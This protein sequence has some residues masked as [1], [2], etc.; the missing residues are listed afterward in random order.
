MT[1]TRHL[2]NVLKADAIQTYADERARIEAHRTPSQH[3]AERH[4][5]NAEKMARLREF[6]AEDDRYQR[7]PAYRAEQ[8]ALRAAR[9]KIV[10]DGMTAA[11]TRN[12]GAHPHV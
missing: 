11:I 5:A 4:V 9:Q 10:S 7:D 1:S 8:D 6:L 3:I 12:K 2:S